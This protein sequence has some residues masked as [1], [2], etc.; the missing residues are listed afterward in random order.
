MSTDPQPAPPAD[1]APA[2][3]PP[4]TPAPPADPA[5]SGLSEADLHR[6]L[7]ARDAKAKAEAEKIKHAPAPEKKDPPAAESTPVNAGKPDTPPGGDGAS[8]PAWFRG[9]RTT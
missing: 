5:P 9:R 2:P 8:A 1:P 3:T 6:I 7:D 4:P